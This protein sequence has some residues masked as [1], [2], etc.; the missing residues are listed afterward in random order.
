MT[1]NHPVA[2]RH[3]H[4]GADALV[5]GPDGGARQRPQQPQLGS[6]GHHR[7][8]LEERASIGAQPHGAGQHGVLH[9]GWDL[10]ARAGQDF[11]HEERV[12]PGLVVQL[13][14]VHAV[15]RRQLAT[16][17]GER[18]ANFSLRTPAVASSPRTLRSGWAFSSASSR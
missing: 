15:R 13:S 17:S 9:R 2:V 18:G 12:A 5:D 4:A 16:A 11:Y 1:E 3:Q 8:R 10:F 6:L 14:A 7:R